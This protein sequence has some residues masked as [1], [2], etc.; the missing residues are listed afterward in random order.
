MARRSLLAG[1]GVVALVV[2]LVVVLGFESTANQLDDSFAD[3]CQAHGGIP[4]RSTEATSEPLQRR[5]LRDESGAR[6]LPKAERLGASS[7]ELYGCEVGGAVVRVFDLGSNAE[8]L[9]LARHHRGPLCLTEAG[10]LEGPNAVLVGRLCRDVEGRL[11]W[12]GDA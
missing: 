8:A 7:I 4:D 5:V 12:P 2:M 3:R 1:A 9:A 10:L 11:L 6:F